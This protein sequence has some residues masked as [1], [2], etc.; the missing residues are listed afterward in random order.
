MAQVLAP[1]GIRGE[2]K[3]RIITDFPRQRFKRGN[4]VLLDGA[5][6]VVQSGR[7]Q[8]QIVLLRL[9]DI[10]DRTTAEKFRGKDILIPVDEAVRLP[11]GQFYWHQVIG[12]EVIDLTTDAS[13][14]RVRDILET[15]ANDVYV[16]KS[17]SGPEILIPAIRDVV[18]DIDPSLGRILVEP[19]PGMLPA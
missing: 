6:H 18:K 7:I 13:L 10:T 4:T 1:H 12:L 11:I 19:L 9:E 3:C 16:V 2:L 15:G 5:T 8:A 14:G 17:D